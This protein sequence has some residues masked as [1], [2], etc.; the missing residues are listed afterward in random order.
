M[1]HHM[2]LMSSDFELGKRVALHESYSNFL[3]AIKFKT[4]VEDYKREFK[5]VKFS[6]HHI[7][8]E[9]KS[10]DSVAEYD[11]YFRDVEF[12]NDATEFKRKIEKSIKITPEDI[13]KYILVKKSYD[14]L[15]IQKLLFLVYSQYALEYDRPLFEDDFEAWKYGP[16]MPRVY[17]KLGDYHREQIKFD[18]IEMEKLKLKLKLSKIPE[19]DEI[20]E[21]IDEVIDKYGDKSGLELV[22]LTHVEGSPWDQVKKKSGL[23]SKIPWILVKEYMQD[24]Y[25]EEA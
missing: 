1:Y 23:N 16:V 8:T 7:E 9:D 3:D 4:T 18:D 14:K 12:Y 20:L 17:S 2:I 15:Q 25:V 10:Y 21:C 11:N 24:K 22:G 5:T 13:A 19:V 6:F